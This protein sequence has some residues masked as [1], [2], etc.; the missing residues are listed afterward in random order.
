MKDRNARFRTVIAFV[1]R[2]KLLTFEGMIR[3]TI[4]LD[5]HGSQGFGYDPVFQPSGY[6]KT[7]AEM[8]PDEKN[9]ISHRALAVKAF[10][11]HFLNEQ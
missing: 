1:E 5:K 7:F 8:A 3:G 9:A 11:K 6:S 2:G 4:T 10:A